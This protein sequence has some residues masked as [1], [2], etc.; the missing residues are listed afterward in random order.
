MIWGVN[1]ETH[2]VEGTSFAPE[3]YKHGNEELE[4]WLRGLLS[5]NASYKFQSVQYKDGIQV[6][7]LT[8]QRAVFHTV[9]FQK[10]DYI[11]VGTYTKKLKDYPEPTCAQIESVRAK[12]SKYI[13]VFRHCQHCRAD[14]VG[15]P[16][17][18]EF[19][20]RIYQRRIAVKET[21]SHG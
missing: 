19:G 11:R 12:A 5:D 16:G 1:N 7:V 4:N 2:E 14:A 8:V 3:E 17:K 9:T 15:V 18:S 6:V 21:F 13:D 20:D 10:N